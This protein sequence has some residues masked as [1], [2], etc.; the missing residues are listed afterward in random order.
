M[1]RD[2]FKELVHTVVGA[3]NPKTCRAG[4]QAGNAGRFL[5]CSSD[6]TP[7]PGTS[8]YGSCGHKNKNKTTII[9]NKQKKKV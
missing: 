3:G 7:S 6:S 9:K 1:H 8:T 5:C 4:W 2:R